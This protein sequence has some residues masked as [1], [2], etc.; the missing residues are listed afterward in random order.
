[1]GVGSFCTT[2]DATDAD[3]WVIDGGLAMNGTGRLKVKGWGDSRLLRAG[4][5]NGSVRMSVSM[6]ED[7]T[8][9]SKRLGYKTTISK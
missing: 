9:L 5:V 1:M 7:I 2:T 3:R 8:A 4:A 6:L